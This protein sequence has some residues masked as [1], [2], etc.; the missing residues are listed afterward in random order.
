[1]K[2]INVA[3]W[4]MGG[5]VLGFFLLPLLI[6]SCGFVYLNFFPVLGGFFLPTMV[7]RYFLAP[8]I[9]LEFGIQGAMMGF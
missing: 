6:G 4:G 5:A 1:M 8:L 7:F 9:F 3:L 2:N